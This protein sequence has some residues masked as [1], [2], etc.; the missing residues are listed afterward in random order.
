MC[1]ERCSHLEETELFVPSADSYNQ[2]CL[3]QAAGIVYAG[4]VFSLLTLHFVVFYSK[5]I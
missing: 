2:M 4:I 3:T 5:Y 1:K